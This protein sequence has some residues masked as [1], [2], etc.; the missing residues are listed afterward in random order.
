M[1]AGPYGTDLRRERLAIFLCGTV[2]LT[3][4]TIPLYCGTA[5][6]A[7]LYH[8]LWHCTTSLWHCSTSLWHCTT[9][10][11][12]VPCGTVPLPVALYHLHAA[13]Y[14]FPAARYHLSA[15]GASGG[16]APRVRREAG[17]SLNLSIVRHYSCR[18]GRAA[19]GRL[20]AHLAAAG[21]CPLGAAAHR[22]RI[23]VPIVVPPRRGARGCAAGGGVW[24]ACKF[25][26]R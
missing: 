5:P 14:R 3:C 21:R 23:L 4:G 17:E 16:S 7:A 20:V 24:G 15:K 11:G 12:T 10:G 18:D 22:V 25:M 19:K 13:L 26:V 9:S 1:G 2:P 6:L 8:L